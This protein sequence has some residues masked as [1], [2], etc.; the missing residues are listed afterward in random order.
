MRKRTSPPGFS[1]YFIPGP[2]EQVFD[3]LDNLTTNLN[4]N[5]LHSVITM[6]ITT[7]NMTI[8]YDHW[9]NGYL[10]GPNGDETYAGGVVGNVLTFESPTIPSN[11]RVSTD[12]CTGSSNPSGATTACYD[13]MDR[14]F[15]V[16]GAVSISQV[17]WSTHP[18]GPCSHTPGRFYRSRCTRQA[19]SCRVGENLY[20]SD[21][22]AYADFDC[23]Y[24]LFQAVEDGTTV[25]F[26][27][28]RTTN[29]STG[30]CGRDLYA[31]LTDYALAKGQS[32]WRG[33]VYSGS[34][35]TSNKPIQVQFIVGREDFQ[36]DSR[37]HTLVPIALWDSEYYSPVPSYSGTNVNLYMYNPTGAILPVTYDDSA[38]GTVTCNVPANG[39]LSVR[40]CKGSFVPAGSAV[41]LTADA[42]FFA[43]G[44]YDS[45]GASYNWGF[46]LVPKSSL[47]SEYFLPWAYGTSNLT[48][49]GSPVFV[50]PTV[51]GQVIYADYSPTNG[52]ANATLN[53]NLLQV[54]KIRDGDNNNTGMRVWSDY[55]FAM[56]WG[57]DDEFA[58][59]NNPYIDA[60]YT[61]LP[62]NPDWIDIAL[63]VDKTANPELIA[64]L[65]GEEVEFTI[66]VKTVDLP[67]N[68]IFI[69]DYLPPY[70]EYVPGTT[71]ITW[72]VGQSYTTDP[73]ITGD[74]TGYTLHWGVAPNNIGDLLAFQTMTLKFKA[75]T[76]APF[77]DT[78]APGDISTNNTSAT[79]YWGDLT[80]TATALATITIGD[81][82]YITVIKDAVQN[83]AQTFPFTLVNILRPQDPTAFSLF[84]D[85]SGVGN[86]ITFGLRPGDYTVTEGPIPAGWVL[87]D[88]VCVDP[89][90]DTTWD[91]DTGV[92]TVPLAAGETVTCTYTNY[93]HPTGVTFIAEPRLA[94]R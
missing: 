11:P 80:L 86:S 35:I 33:G 88:L 55:P 74:A 18:M 43:I 22:T 14:I 87:H 78:Y 10:T 56:V 32:F 60:G 13:G 58:G 47:N 77:A 79:G 23:V 90:N 75:K 67:I 1:E 3:I 2:E 50:T 26:D 12:A 89:S 49:N 54:G 8:Y 30:T 28:Q 81:P 6:P 39:A 20:A 85:G 36:W 52:V 29:P 51:N 46:S 70:F 19:T 16:G 83:S 5:N 27:N 91:L 9:E 15:V 62:P 92:S 66:D 76:I 37:S 59:A 72:P 64:D 42:D 45:G 34:T 73:V 4:G 7:P 24:V 69:E 48:A 41:H 82:G 17:F 65:D 63:D 84:D 25:S 53:L 44:E 38:A 71:L 40:A 94:G 21:S 57:E 31:D 93:D 68:N 61:I